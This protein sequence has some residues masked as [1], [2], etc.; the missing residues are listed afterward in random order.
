MIQWKVNILRGEKFHF[1]TI[2][3]IVFV[4]EYTNQADPRERATLTVQYLQ[5]L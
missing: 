4:T 2:L 3:R 5:F 1:I